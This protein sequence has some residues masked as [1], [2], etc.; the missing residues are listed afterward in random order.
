MKPS[1][2][3]C[4]VCK[5]PFAEEKIAMTQV[6]YTYNPKHDYFVIGFDIDAMIQRNKSYSLICQNCFKYIGEIYIKN[7]EK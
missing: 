5:R 4:D 7:K 6:S 2:F 3:Y 1:V